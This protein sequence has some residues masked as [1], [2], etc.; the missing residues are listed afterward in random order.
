MN[1]DCGDIFSKEVLEKPS[2]RGKYQGTT[3]E[4]NTNNVK[5]DLGII[6][7]HSNCLYALNLSSLSSFLYFKF[8]QRLTLFYNSILAIG[9][10]GIIT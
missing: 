9:H 5:E 1:V 4:S 3:R 8:S 2:H 10:C 7:I 6:E